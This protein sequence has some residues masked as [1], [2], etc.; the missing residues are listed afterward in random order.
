[1]RSREQFMREYAASH[2]QI[3][4]Q[5][6][7][8]IC[9][10]IIFFTSTGLLWSVPLDGLV[11]GSFDSQGWFNLATLVAL[12]ITVFYARLG[13]R[14]LLTGIT[15]MLIGGLG[16]FALQSVGAPLVGLCIGLWLAAWVVQ[17]YGHKLEGAK[18]SFFDDLVFLLI[19]PLFVHEKLVRLATTGTIH[20]RA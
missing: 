7:H 12:P 3:T 18:P 19:G 10:P 16:S 14:S 17:L 2:G 9:V 13:A 6:I 1:M 20:A 8:M 5:I 15:W 4:N 11:P